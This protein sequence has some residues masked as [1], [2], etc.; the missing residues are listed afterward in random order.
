MPIAFRAARGRAARHVA[1]VFF[2]MP[3]VALAVPTVPAPPAAAGADR[4]QQAAAA[5]ARCDEAA[6]RAPVDPVARHRLGVCFL[7]GKGRL[8]DHARALDL[9]RDAAEAGEVAAEFSLA[10][11]ILFKTELVDRFADAVARLEALAEAGFSPAHFPLAVARFAGMGGRRDMAAALHHFDRAAVAGDDEMAAWVLAVVYRY[12]LWD[13]PVDRARALSYARRYLALLGARFP[14]APVDA[15]G[16]R[17]SVLG[18]HHDRLLRRFVFADTE[19]ERFL[20]LADEVAASEL[21]L[22]AGAAPGN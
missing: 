15:A 17:L 12:G 6:A 1:G 5:R 11:A 14:D 21:P 22:P 4:V 16:L 3:F 18:L 13:Q 7:L 9:L 19:L 2:V 20:E 8:A 10:A